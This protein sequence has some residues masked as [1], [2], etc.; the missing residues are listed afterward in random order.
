MSRF[1][2]SQIVQTSRGRKQ[3]VQ[4]SGSKNNSLVV[5]VIKAQGL[6]NVLKLDKQSPYVSVRIQ[7]Q[8]ECTRTVWRGGQ[9][10]IF[11]DELWFNLNGTEEKIL[12]I[13]VYH[14]GKK[15]A[16]LVCCGEVDFTTALR[17]SV[18]EG[19]DGWFDLYWE[20]RNAGKVYLEITYYPVKGEVP[21]GTKNPARSQMEKSFSLPRSSDGAFKYSRNGGHQKPNFNE[22]DDIP[23]LGELTS[24][25]SRSDNQL[26]NS[27]TRTPS[28]SPTKRAGKFFSN[29]SS[30]NKDGTSHGWLTSM[31]NNTFGHKRTDTES[32][33]SSDISRTELKLKS[34]DLVQERPRNLFK[35]DSDNGESD[36]DGLSDISLTEKLK[37]SIA[38]KQ[39]AL[40]SENKR[41]VSSMTYKSENSDTESDDEFVVGQ[42]VDFKLSGRTN[43]NSPSRKIDF[44]NF[45]D[46]EFTRSYQSKRLPQVTSRYKYCSDSNNDSDSSVDLPPPPPKHTVSIGNLFDSVNTKSSPVNN[47]L[48][49]T[50]KLPS[51]KSATGILPN[52]PG[53]DKNTSWYEKRK[54]ERRKNRS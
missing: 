32:S 40:L 53:F 29:H 49:L 4:Q 37:R 39:D 31:I 3:H 44:K 5:V 48:D 10:P 52:E 42:A 13:N 26:R 20:G 24:K 11:N 28:S 46:D 36:D 51:G 30:P 1:E 25:N 12:Y 47:H 8:E 35:S 14:Q 23:E 34:P 17:K 54:S 45:E 21:I 33:M 38:S 16:K 19:Y 2:T 6:R 41:I 22:E 7:D 27:R 9:T 18:T 15:D 50:D 43:N